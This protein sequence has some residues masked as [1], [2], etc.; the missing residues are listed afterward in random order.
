MWDFIKQVLNFLRELVFERL[1]TLLKRKRHPKQKVERFTDRANHVLAVS[2]AEAERLRRPHIQPQHVLIA[3]LR[4]EGSIGQQILCRAGV[5]PAHVLASPWY[6]G[7]V[8]AHPPEWVE[9]AAATQRLLELAV[10]EAYKY[11]DD[12]VATEHLLAALVQQRDSDA[13]RI[14]RDLGHDPAALY[15]AVWQTMALLRPYYAYPSSD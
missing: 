13:A 12:C 9:L 15:R 14:L 10:G 6:D 2:Q 5:T 3:L 7:S 4:E 8:A 1:P 11:D